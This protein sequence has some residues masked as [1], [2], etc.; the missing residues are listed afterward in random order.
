MSNRRLILFALLLA[1]LFVFACSAATTTNP[2][3][4]IGEPAESAGEEEEAVQEP[5]EESAVEEPGE[6]PAL[7]SPPEATAPPSNPDA[8]IMP[9]DL[10]Y[11]GAFRLPSDAPDE[12]GWLWSGNALTFYPDGDP[13]GSA[14][15]Y[16]GS[17]FGT[18]HNWNTYVSEIDIPQPVISAAK[19]LEELNTAATLQPFADIQGGMFGYLEIPRVGLEYL[20]AQG[21]QDSGK[22]YFAWAQHMGEGD[23]FATHGWAD[24]D[25]SNP[26]PAGLWHIGDL[27]NYV[28]GDYL[29]EIPAEWADAYTGGRSLATGRF[30]DGGQGAEG[31]SIFAIAPWQEGNPPPDGAALPYVTLL[32]YDDV[33]TDNPAMMNDYHHSDEWN[34]AAWLTAGDRAAVVF[35]GNKGHGENWYGCSDGTVWEEPYPEACAERGWWSTSFEAQI[36]FYDPA[37]L[38][39]AATGERDPRESQPYAVLSIDDVL[40]NSV[41]G[42]QF[43]ERLGAAAFD[44]AS[45]LLYV[46]EQFGDEDKPL[47]HVWRIGE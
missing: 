39:A 27:P 11:V 26:Q 33:T 20:P 32:T 47:I 6:E 38:A 24:L 44:R 41:P 29:F 18:G 3:E 2:G 46:M 7:V 16:P 13:S 14:D 40:Y 23:T 19:N 31:P 8:L 25:L 21:D 45:G 28:T 34:G 1:V 42:D 37:D 36:I 5:V 22:L 9:D 17:L 4:P 30:R 12:F 10:V 43:K 35:A 15:G